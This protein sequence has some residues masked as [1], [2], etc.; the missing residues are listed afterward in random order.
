MKFT[1]LQMRV[2]SLL[3][4]SLLLTASCIIGYS[5]SVM[6]STARQARRQGI[7]QAKAYAVAISRQYANRVE[8]YLE[9]GLEAVRVLAQTLRIAADARAESRLSRAE[10]TR[11]LKTVIE[12]RPDFL[13]IYT[14]WEPNA[15]DGMDHE[16]VNHPGHDAT[17]RFI[18]YWTRNQAGQILLEPLVDYEIAGAG[19][20][21]Q[22]PR[23]T[24]KEQLL[25][26]NA[27]LVQGEPI[28][29]TSL[30]VPILSDETFRGVVGIDLRLDVF[31]PLVND[32]TGV[33]NQQ[34]AQLLIISSNGTI[35]AATRQPEL[36]GKPLQ[37]V[38]E[39][40]RDDLNAAIKRPDGYTKIEED[41]L[42]VFCRVDVGNTG[43][44]WFVKMTLPETAITHDADLLLQQANRD[45]L[46]MIA[47]SLICLAAAS[48]L[49]WDMMRKI[50]APVTDAAVFAEELARG[51]LDATLRLHQNNELGVLADALRSM[52]EKIRGA[53]QE[54]SKIIQAAQAG[55][56]NARGNFRDFSG[57][58]RELGFGLNHVLDA[59]WSPFN[60]AAGHLER[61]AN[62]EIPATIPIEAYSG[63]LKQVI[64][65]LNQCIETITGLA[66][67]TT[68]LTN[69]AMRGRFNFRGDVEKFGGEYAAIVKGMNN[70]IA[71]LVGHIDRIPVAIHV[72]DAAFTIQ[73]VNAAG[74]AIVGATPEQLIGQKCY[75]WFRTSACQTDRCAC[76][77]AISSGG[78]HVCDASAH[79]GN[80][81]LFL[82]Q[83]GIPLRDEH[84]QIIGALEMLVDQTEIKAA[85]LAAQQQNW[86][87]A[88]Q[89]ELS[90][91]MRGEQ[92]A[93]PLARSIIAYLAQ[94]LSADIG[95][96]YLTQDDGEQKSLILT[97]STA[98]SR[99]MNPENSVAFG[100]GLVGQAAIEEEQL[101]FTDIPGDE[102]PIQT[103][104][105][106]VAPRQILASPFWH[107]G[108]LTGVIELGTLGEFSPAHQEFLKHT[109]ENIAAAIHSAQTRVKM[110]QLLAQTQ[111]HIATTSNVKKGEA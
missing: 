42:E 52:K 84:D 91:V 79:R 109:A 82:T 15:F 31:Q 33:N 67:E 96:I 38:E 40:W 3:G 9:T 13:G 83:T 92:D 44:S 111:Q 35:I 22:L 28:L 19:N 8:S 94:Y 59:F 104:S 64:L 66:A 58:W 99:R 55:R 100:A 57:G 4:I 87:R 110:R 89:A 90:S 56:L 98:Y 102:L 39:D 95:A 50:I 29:L 25:D 23:K 71:M 26:A 32:V 41:R 80:R 2:A 37:T 76:A 11:L 16:F 65:N 21:Y 72:I 97:A 27:Y 103:E 63:D 70:T 34:A 54:T 60:I 14:A 105:G 30:V 73:Y 12:Q 46:R 47:I 107:D 49:M 24:G 48:Q 77:Q 93:Q 45:I 61:L 86:L 74:A 18:P 43:A 106:F 62:G 85:M 6:H 53:L 7:A 69:A 51:N 1:G 36:A 20:Y 68:A 10:V 78:I 75:D 81:A 17:G 108:G 88:G 5:A 101:L